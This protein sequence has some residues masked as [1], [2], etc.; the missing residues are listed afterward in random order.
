MMKL[1]SLASLFLAT[2]CPSSEARLREANEVGKLAYV[3]GSVGC[4]LKGYS[5]E[6][7]DLMRDAFMNL[8]NSSIVQT[9]WTSLARTASYKTN[10]IAPPEDSSLSQPTLSFSNLEDSRSFPLCHVWLRNVTLAATFTTA[11]FTQPLT[12]RLCMGW[13]R[14][15]LKAPKSI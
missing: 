15:N 5:L 12:R 4:T 2:F 14:N 8:L 10:T 7:V 3:C 6:Y 11:K 13:N 9:A 1:I